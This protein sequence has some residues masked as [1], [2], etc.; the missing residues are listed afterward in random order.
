MNLSHFLVYAT[1]FMLTMMWYLRRHFRFERKSLEVHVEAREAG[2]LE[3]ASLHPVIDPIRCI[4]C[5]LCYVACDK[6][7][8]ITLKPVA[9][10]V[11]PIVKKMERATHPLES[12]SGV[13]E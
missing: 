5:G 11:I 9:D 3:P 1:P 8:A 4:G 12:I 6:E 7:K 10:Y 13:K 2:L